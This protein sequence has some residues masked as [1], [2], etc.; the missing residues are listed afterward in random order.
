MYHKV[1]RASML[2]NLLMFG[3]VIQESIDRLSGSNKELNPNP[4]LASLEL[5]YDS[6][7]VYG[8]MSVRIPDS[9]RVIRI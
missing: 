8:W 4:G 2:A 1:R 9:L 5:F 7:E 3:R 6:P